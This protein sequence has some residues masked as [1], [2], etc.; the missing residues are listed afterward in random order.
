MAMKR[1]AGLAL[2]LAGC[3]TVTQVR[4]VLELP[5]PQ[6]VQSRRE[7][8]TATIFW[9]AGAESR[10]ADFDGYLLYVSPRSLATAPLQ[11]M[12]APIV[13]AKGVTEHTIVIGDSL[14][15]FIHVRSRAGRNKISLPSL[16]E[17]IIK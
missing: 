4:D 14:P 8:N 11:D 3:A 1:A 15:L 2:L 5:P 16:P 12:P 13:I 10:Q 7:S 17:L 9:P 6:Q